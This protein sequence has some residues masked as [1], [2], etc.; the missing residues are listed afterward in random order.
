M[1]GTK[2]LAVLAG[3]VAAAVA[4]GAASVWMLSE[5]PAFAQAQ[6]SVQ[7]VVRAERVVI[8]DG[9][10]KERARFGISEN[11]AASVEF[12]GED[13]Q[14]TRVS[15]GTDP[16]GVPV[17]H[18]LGKDGKAQAT[19]SMAPGSKPFLSLS[20]ET[21]TPRVMLLIGTEGSADLVFSDR[22]GEEFFVTRD[23]LEEMDRKVAELMVEAPMKYGKPLI[24]I[25]FDRKLET[26]MFRQSEI[27]SQAMKSAGILSFQTLE[28]AAGAMN[29]LVRYG[30][31]KRRQQQ[32][33]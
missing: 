22:S 30:I 24:L 31:I 6:S 7:K 18:I 5:K 10:G 20:D 28:D 15:L 12:F 8:V 26:E 14:E 9:G 11:G 29:A 2:S 25:G 3:F 23:E 21:G 1:R 13:G 4:G 16:N 33:Q 19:V 32:E 17:L 27:I